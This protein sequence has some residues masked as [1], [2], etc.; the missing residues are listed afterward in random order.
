M[1]LNFTEGNHPFLKILGMY[2]KLFVQLVLEKGVGVGKK[3][4]FIYKWFKCLRSYIKKLKIK[5]CERNRCQKKKRER[6]WSSAL[7][8]TPRA[9]GGDTELH[10]GDI[11]SQGGG[12]LGR[13]G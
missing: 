3:D 9:Q 2:F 13:P 11:G 7:K 1:W 10:L 5:S 6:F 4:F 8:H 12:G